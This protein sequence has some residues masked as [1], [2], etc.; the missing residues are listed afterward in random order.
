M[1][2]KIINSNYL[3]YLVLA[4]VPLLILGPFLPDLIISLSSIFFL[5]FVF[6]KKYFYLFHNKVFYLFIIFCLICI[7]SSILS[8]NIIFSFYGSLFYFRIGIFAFFIK[9]LLDKNP[10]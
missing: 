2:E 5:I 3:H 6:K 8:K 1:L 9:Y 7:L 4:V 10:E